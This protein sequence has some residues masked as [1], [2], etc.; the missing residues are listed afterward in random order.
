MTFS[1][2]SFSG[3]RCVLTCA[4]LVC[5]LYIAGAQ[6][7]TFDDLAQTLKQ[8]LNDAAHKSFDSA[9]GNTTSTSASTAAAASHVASSRAARLERH[10]RLLL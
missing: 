8:G 5:A 9:I 6:A 10:R 2:R 3:T 4:G 1:S 7:G